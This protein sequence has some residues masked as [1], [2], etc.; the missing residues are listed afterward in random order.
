MC[1]SPRC[2][3]LGSFSAVERAATVRVTVSERSSQYILQSAA[4]A[5]LSN[6][7]QSVS[8]GEKGGG[9][10]DKTKYTG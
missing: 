9:K 4:G 2:T 5:C 3:T 6:S 10:E 7:L 1:T 8:G